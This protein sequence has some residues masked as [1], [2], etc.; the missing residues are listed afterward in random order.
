MSVSD[1]EAALK[2]LLYWGSWSN[3]RERLEETKQ[4]SAAGTDNGDTLED[5][6]ATCG[7]HVQ[8]DMS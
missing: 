8:L 3:W 1:P 4:L 6:E 5:V 7:N 2:L